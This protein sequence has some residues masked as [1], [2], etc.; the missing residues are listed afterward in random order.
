M[1]N[2]STLV[3]I[4]LIFTFCIYLFSSDQI[5]AQDA[6]ILE[7][8]SISNIQAKS[9]IAKKNNRID[10]Y[11][12]IHN[13]HPTIYIDNNTIKK[14]YGNNP[15]KKIT[16]ENSQSYSIL[17]SKN[18]NYKSVELITL[19]LESIS[20]LNNPIDLSNI[21]EFENLKYVYVKCYFKHTADDIKKFI[22]TNSNVRVFHIY[23]KPS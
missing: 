12:L 6:D 21:S 5:V 9:S 4:K 16:I 2:K 1:K 17:N 20:D 13:L 14:I 7:L 15:I 18:N 22:K 19:K 11:N 23:A 8:N 3:L 10:F